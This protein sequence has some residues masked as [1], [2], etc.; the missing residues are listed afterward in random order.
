MEVID[1]EN[2]PEDALSTPI[3]GPIPLIVNGLYA[4]IPPALDVRMSSG[5]SG[6]ERGLYTKY[7]RRPGD[8]LLSLKPHVAALSNKNLEEHCSTCFAP[9]SGSLRR[10]TGC[11]VLYYC[12]A[13]C[14]S[15]DWTFHRQECTAIQRW[16][17]SLQRSG[18]D[19]LVI[20]GDAIRCLARIVWR[21]QKLGHD[22]VWA[23]EID[24]LQSH[25]TSLNKD[26]NSQE[27][28]MYAQLAHALVHFLGLNSP[29][30]LAEYGMQSAADLVDLISRLTTN[31]FTVSTPALEPLGACV[32]PAVALIN[33]SCDP[34]A[35]VVF[36]RAG[37]ESTKDEEPLMQV[38]ALKHI[39]PDEE[40]LTAYID[41]TLPREKR[42]KI[43][44][45]TYHFTCQCTL[46]A[47]P[48]GSPIDLREAMWCPKKCGG[49]CP[50]PTEENSLTRCSRCKAP[51]KDTDAVLDA[52][53]VGQEALDKAEAL[54]VSNPQKSI[55]L[56]TKLIPILISAG[57]VP[58][59]HPLL[60]LSRLNSSLL[61]THLPSMDP[62][63]E[64][65]LSPGVQAQA[66]LQDTTHTAT[67]GR[68]EAQEA[69]DDA[70]RA[71][72]RASTGLSQI[73]VEGH[74]VRG[75]ALAELGKLLSVDEPDPAHVEPRLRQRR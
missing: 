45:E 36:P 38:I 73:L 34:N 2:S 53:R 25:R 67:V 74:P 69:L 16:S 13:K 18:S 62:A 14:Q 19:S 68:K 54:Q 39:A 30:E 59:S 41:T 6:K 5:D 15:R 12:D 4:S 71:A 56:T 51:V 70:I 47:P 28:Q 33:H 20:P 63:I 50:L 24:A 3:T 22:S 7:P 11:K 72:T 43:L 26:P 48:P 60:A 42:Q 49:V 40:I 61:I 23:R 17:S 10:C 27:S 21:K 66:Q 57:L 35:V 55:Q 64:E 37:G 44:K 29:Q 31:T 52:I 58:G 75:I 8:V 65:V 46:C 1:T 32:S 9:K